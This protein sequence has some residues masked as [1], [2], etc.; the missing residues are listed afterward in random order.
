[1]QTRLAYELDPDVLKW[2]ALKRVMLRALRL[3]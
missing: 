1:M 3:R 2:M